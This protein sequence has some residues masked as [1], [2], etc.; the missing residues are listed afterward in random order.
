MYQRFKLSFQWLSNMYKISTFQRWEVVI[1]RYNKNCKSKM[2]IN[3]V[4]H[5]EL[6]A[7]V[8]FKFNFNCSD[9]ESLCY[10]LI[11]ITFN[12]Y[13]S[14]L[15]TLIWNLSCWMKF[16]SSW[17]EKWARRA[18]RASLLIISNLSQQKYRKYRG[19]MCYLETNPGFVN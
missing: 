2:K 7:T 5:L 19:V 16:C 14:A 9:G 10:K 4:L 3:S 17:E 6:K 15:L 12:L 11:W 13:S 18:R 8:R 1:R